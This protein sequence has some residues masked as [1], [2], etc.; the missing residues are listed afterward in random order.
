MEILKNKLEE[1]ISLLSKDDSQD[2]KDRISTS[3][4][5]QPFNEYEY[6]IS[7]LFALNRL[8]FSEYLEIRDEYI[9]RNMHLYVFEISAPR[10]FG[11]KWAQG[12]ILGLVPDFI[13]PTKKLDEN[14][15]G[16]YD[17]LYDLPSKGRIKI[18]V[19]ASRV[20]DSNSDQ[21]L[22]IKALSSES[23]LPFDMNFQQIKPKCCD[24]FIWIGVWRDTIKYWVLSSREVEGNRY[25][26]NK[27]HRGNRGEGQLHVKDANIKEFI[28][29]SVKLTDILEKV[30]MAYKRQSE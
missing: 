1:I 3:V 17:L 10:T 30:K 22:Y 20:V 2:I 7:S 21:P 8:T 6:I 12:H 24:V 28:R 11:E 19:K 4:S 26:S 18:E 29:Y 14:Y 13:K 23:K 16:Q 25:Y 5:M 27:Q 9:A 15:A